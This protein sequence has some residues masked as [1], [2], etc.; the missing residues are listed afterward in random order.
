MANID[1]ILG[2]INDRLKGIENLLD[3][4]KKRSEKP[5]SE[6]APER[7]FAAVCRNMQDGRQYEI[8]DIIETELKDGTTAK[9]RIIDKAI[10]VSGACARPLLTVQLAEILDYRWFSVPSKKFPWGCNEYK[11]SDIG[12]WLNSEFLSRLSNE[13]TACIHPATKGGI[14]SAHFWLLS[15]DEAGFGDLEEAYQ[16]YACEDADERDRRRQLK[17][18]D[19]DAAHWWLRTPTASLGVGVRIVIS[20][21]SLGGNGAYGAFGAAPACFIG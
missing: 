2:E 3:F 7:G 20:D 6:A 19:G 5:E 11:T 12:A 14:S 1:L 16:Y 18:T 17:D 4:F 8:G 13:D 10:D 21:G 9:W 15:S